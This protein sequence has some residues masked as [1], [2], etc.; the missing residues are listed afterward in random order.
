MYDFKIMQCLK[1]SD[2]LDE[3]VP[4]FFLRHILAFLLIRNDLVIQVATVSV[5]H[6]DAETLSRILEERLFVRDNVVIPNEEYKGSR[7]FTR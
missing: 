7:E 2:Y 6:Y 3:V 1:T 5:L 4:G